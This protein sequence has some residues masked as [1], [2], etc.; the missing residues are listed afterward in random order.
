MRPPKNALSFCRV[1]SSTFGHT[2]SRAR[3]YTESIVFLWAIDI[4]SLAQ[5]CLKQCCRNSSLSALLL[6]ISVSFHVLLGPMDTCESRNATMTRCEGPEDENDDVSVTSTIE[7][8]VDSDE[9]F[10]LI[11][12]LAERLIGKVSHVP[13]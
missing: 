2:T 11:K 6:L 1:S 12:I 7:E 4:V 9:E 3:Y 10:H 13:R 8:T 5:V